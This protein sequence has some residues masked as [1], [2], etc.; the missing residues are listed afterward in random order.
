VFNY[1]YR[2]HNLRFCKTPKLKQTQTVFAEKRFAKPFYRRHNLRFCKTP[3]LKQTQI[4]L[5]AGNILTAV[6]IGVTSA[7]QTG[8]SDPPDFFLN[9]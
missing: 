9:S 4:V 1:P 8:M 2:R 5:S 6:I 3:K 7:D